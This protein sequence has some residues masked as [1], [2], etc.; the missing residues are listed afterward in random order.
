MQV[1]ETTN[2]KFYPSIVIKAYVQDVT[3][4]RQPETRKLPVL[5]TVVNSSI[6][7]LH[8]Q[9][10]SHHCVLANCQPQTTCSSRQPIS[11]TSESKD[12]TKPAQ[13]VCNQL[14]SVSEPAVKCLSVLFLKDTQ[15]WPSSLHKVCSNFKS[16]GIQNHNPIL[17]CT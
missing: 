3:Q 15:H 5:F 1:H 13:T 17:T 11:S 7:N 10:S 14:L 16:D 9:T 2:F 4:R 8:H 6:Q 12:W